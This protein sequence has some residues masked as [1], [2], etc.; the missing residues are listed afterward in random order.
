MS[1]VQPFPPGTAAAIYFK[2]GPGYLFVKSLGIGGSA[3]TTLVRT[4]GDGLNTH[5]PSL[6]ARKRT[7][8][9]DYSNL[10]IPIPYFM[11]HCPVK[12]VLFPSDPHPSIPAILSSGL[13]PNTSREEG[14]YTYQQFCNGG[15]LES[16][17]HNHHAARR[18]VPEAFIWK[19]L[20]TIPMLLR[21]LHNEVSTPI[22]HGDVQGDNIFLHYPDNSNNSS[23][24]T[25]V[26]PDIYLGD[27][28][29]ARPLQDYEAHDPLGEPAW[30][31]Q[32]TELRA[33]LDLAFCLVG[34]PRVNKVRCLGFVD[35][36]A[37]AQEGLWEPYSVALQRA[38]LESDLWIQGAVA[39]DAENRW[40]EIPKILERGWKRWNEYQSSGEGCGMMTDGV[41]DREDVSWTRPKYPVQP[42]LMNERQMAE[43]V[44]GTSES[45]PEIANLK[46]R[47]YPLESRW[48][49]IFR[50]WEFAVVKADTLE[51]VKVLSEKDELA[52]AEHFG[53]L[54]KREPVIQVQ[55]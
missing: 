19:Y 46:G 6:L 55:L 39:G 48:R 25:E 32:T 12:E 15:T 26:L 54:A 51:V 34:A 47:R 21:W 36:R 24:S 28:G 33:S 41:G 2:E 3:Q 49:W 29:H 42:L 5:S 45:I 23:S 22:V 30:Y 43:I 7:D 1:N 16:L 17:I 13:Y 50:P 37:L 18:P 9:P 38:M 14:Y 10:G 27:F 4:V 31:A 11:H 40:E 53:L 20:L 52:L 8:R 44:A 35:L